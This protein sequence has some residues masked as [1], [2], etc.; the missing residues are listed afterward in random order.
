[1][2]T[3][4]RQTKEQALASKE[5]NRFNLILTIILVAVFLLTMLANALGVLRPAALDLSNGGFCVKV[6]NDKEPDIFGIAGAKNC[7]EAP[8]TPSVPTPELAV[9][10]V[11]AA[12]NAENKIFALTRSGQINEFTF[13]KESRALTG[14]VAIS[15]VG[16]N[17]VNSLGLTPKGEFF[18][19]TATGALYS[20]TPGGASKQVA[21]S[22]LSTKPI[23]GA[24]MIYKGQAE[25]Y[26]GTMAMLPGVQTA[27]LTVY[28][29]SPTAERTGLVFETQIVGAS[30]AS[31]DFSFAPS[32]DLRVVTGQDETT[33]ASIPFAAFADLKAGTGAVLEEVK[34][35][36]KVFSGGT[37]GIGGGANGVAFVGDFMALSSS[38]KI[39]VY[40]IASDGIWNYTIPR[41]LSAA[42]PITDLASCQIN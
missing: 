4:I 20:H 15:T 19:T 23:A 11:C 25:Y 26:V 31:G 28:R 39:G 29:D 24:S 17:D 34:V 27:K 22:S 21:S 2:T 35:D 30:G 3:N 36:G 10:G 6:A 33:L 1:M 40:Q 37:T 38:L 8:V 13:D 32:G 41:Q 18:F 12:P 16:Q 42:D 5:R 14:P 7:G 9:A